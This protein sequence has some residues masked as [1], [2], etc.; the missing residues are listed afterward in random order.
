MLTSLCITSLKQSFTSMEFFLKYL[1]TDIKNYWAKCFHFF[2]SHMTVTSA[3]GRHV[4]ARPGGVTIFEAVGSKIDTR[5]SS[6]LLVLPH[7]RFFRGKQ[8]GVICSFSL[9]GVSVQSTRPQSCRVSCVIHSSQCSP[10]LLWWLRLTWCS[11]VSWLLTL[12]FQLQLHLKVPFP[13]R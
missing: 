8:S 6:C 13:P 5:S 10:G 9:K 11:T 4:H 1:R 2:P 7:R 3:E 12:T